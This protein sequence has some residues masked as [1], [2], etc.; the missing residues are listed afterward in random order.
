MYGFSKDY[1]ERKIFYYL[2]IGIVLTIIVVVAT[3]ISLVFLVL[4]TQISNPSTA[5][6]SLTN[7]FAYTTP[8]F[9]AASII[10]VLYNVKA[11]NLLSDKS[12][13]PLFRTGAWILLAGAIMTVIFEVAFTVVSVSTSMS[14]SSFTNSLTVIAVPGA[15]VQGVAWVLFAKSYYRITPPPAQTAPPYSYP[16]ISPQ[17]QYCPNCGTQNRTDARFCTHCGQKL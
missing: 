5:T 4:A 9:G 10:W 6:T 7:A 16:P 17:I 13:V 1:A 15:I 11:F 8:V 3:T 12:G 2:L 14:I